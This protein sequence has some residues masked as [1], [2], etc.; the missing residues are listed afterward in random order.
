MSS[1]EVYISDSRIKAGKNNKIIAREC[2]V[3]KG[4]NGHFDITL[5]RRGKSSYVVEIYMKLQFFFI[6]GD[7]NKSGWPKKGDHRWTQKEKNDFMIDW[8]R[9][10]KTNWSKNNIGKLSDGKPISVVVNFTVKQ[11]GWMWDHFEI[12]VTKLPPI[13]SSFKES[14]VNRRVFDAD[15]ELD[16]K[17]LKPKA[18]GQRAAIH[19]FGHMI[20][21]PNEYKRKSPHYHDRS[22]IMNTGTLIS[23]RHF[24]IIIKWANKQ[25]K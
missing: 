18:S 9:H 21:L 6:D 10:V 17:D 5:L 20:G 16:S 4:K 8:Y 1:K 12:D 23:K 25:I 15:V 19:E 22:S 24:D 3:E 13:P 7:E 2:G 14:F 11:G